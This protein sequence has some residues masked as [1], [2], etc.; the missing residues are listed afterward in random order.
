[1][2]RVEPTTRCHVWFA[3]VCGFWQRRVLRHHQVWRAPAA[4]LSQGLVSVQVLNDD[5][6]HMSN[7]A[8][9][10][11]MEVVVSSI[12]RVSGLM[13]GGTLVAVC[14]SNLMSMGASVH[15]EFGGVSSLARVASGEMFHCSS[16]VGGVAGHVGLEMSLNG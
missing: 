3:C 11:E 15:C 5:V 9:W 2:L 6:L 4:S 7:V 12:W 1:M 16:P 8:C 10:Y 14:G 13:S